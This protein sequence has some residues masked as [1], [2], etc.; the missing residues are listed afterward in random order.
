M[1]LESL[2]L[3]VITL[4]FVGLLALGVLSS[5]EQT[6]YDDYYLAGRNVP[7]LL[8]GVSVVATLLSSVSFVV[9]PGEMIRNGIG[10]FSSMVAFVLIIP[11]VNR[12]VIPS[13]MRLPVTTIY[14][15]LEWRFGIPA[16]KLGA[17]VFVVIRL[18]WM[19][20][21]LYTAARAITPMTGWSLPPLV[22]AMG[23]VTVFYTTLGGMR[24]VLWSDFAQFVILV[25]GALL[26]PCY[27]AINTSS[28]PSDW[29]SVFAQGTRA[30]TPIFSFDPTERTTLVG[31]VMLTFLW[32]ICTHS[33]DQVAAQRY[34]CTRTAR[35][36]KNSFWVFSLGNIAIITLLMICG[37]ALYYF[38]FLND[39]LP[40]AEFQERITAE[41]DEVMP[42]FIAKH[43]PPGVTGLILAA[44]L[45]AAMSSVSS[46]INS[47]SA[48]VA[49]DLM[50][51]AGR[52]EAEPP[53]LT[54]P[55]L[56]ALASGGIAIA[57]AL[58]VNAM[59][60]VVDWNLVDLIERINH[61]FVAPLGAVFFAGIW[62]RHVGLGA[63]ILDFVAGVATSITV[64]FSAAI[65]DYDIS[66]M[67]ILP[68]SFAM[69]I[70][71]A[72]VIGFWLEAPSDSQ[73]SVLYQ[74]PEAPDKGDKYI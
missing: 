47:I 25:G 13:L 18:I 58:L 41:A 15:Y 6:S 73:L 11:T 31:M 39:A 2:D 8:A 20:L 22:L 7:W 64:S 44:L 51:K 63:V 53:S 50:N 26:I 70:F 69:S 46:G 33:S 23:L 71:V 43:L 68:S 60:S 65:F 57:G 19:G 35:E 62:F 12:V 3:V 40:M 4:Y 32:N 55:R 72:Y 9:L 10:Y 61:L 21:I 34:L 5:R 30:H 17:T 42:N 74:P 66:F 52:T 45:A 28:G 1:H 59:M 27:I 14:D 29:W 54:M 37:L 16:R 24:A 67:W 49:T 38:R 48:V 56:L 36:A